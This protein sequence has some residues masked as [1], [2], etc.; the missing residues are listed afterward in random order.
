M[1]NFNVN[2]EAVNGVGTVV[3]IDGNKEY[4]TTNIPMQL[5]S[6][7]GVAVGYKRVD[8][9]NFDGRVTFGRVY[10]IAEIHD[11]TSTSE[12]VYFK[13]INNQEFYSEI[14]KLVEK[15]FQNRRKEF[16]EKTVRRYSENH[17]LSAL[18]RCLYIFD[19]ERYQFENEQYNQETQEFFDSL[20][21]N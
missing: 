9:D 3:E 12:L 5:I 6:M 8:V 4:V 1:T 14:D 17:M 20:F 13:A 11:E 16:V 15:R 19:N 10:P 21:E 18:D 7:D 2:I